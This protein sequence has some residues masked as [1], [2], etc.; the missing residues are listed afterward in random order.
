MK[1]RGVKMEPMRI[2]IE[3]KNR[4]HKFVARYTSI[5]VVLS[6]AIV[7][8]WKVHQMDVK[9]PFLNGLIEE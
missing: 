9:M 5:R 8:K 7:M 6:I 4:V 1:E 2:W 3:I